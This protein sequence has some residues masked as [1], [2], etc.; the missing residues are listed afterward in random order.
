MSERTERLR[1]E[2]LA[3]VPSITG[4]RAA[5]VTGFYREHYGRHS[6]PVLR[7][8]NFLEIV[9]RKALWWARAN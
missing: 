3:A 4:E 2:S 8:L 7:G 1:Q 5:I 9:E 6:M